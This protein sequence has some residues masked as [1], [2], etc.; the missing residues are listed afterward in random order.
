MITSSPEFA[1]H[2]DA[3]LFRDYLIEHS[4]VANEYERL[5]RRLAATHLNDRETYTSGKSEF[6]SRVTTQAKSLRRG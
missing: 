3:L 5:K 4:E 6:V 1:P 2:W